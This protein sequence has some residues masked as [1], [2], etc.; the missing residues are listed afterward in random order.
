MAPGRRGATEIDEPANEVR[1]RVALGGLDP[2]L[3][4]VELYADPGAVHGRETF[5]LTPSVDQ[6]ATYVGPVPAHRALA[7]FTA[8]IVPN[9]A[10]LALPLECPLVR[11]QQ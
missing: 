9:V 11:W 2:A 1:V 6:P 3:L 4:R 5:A 7:E 8:R 10:D